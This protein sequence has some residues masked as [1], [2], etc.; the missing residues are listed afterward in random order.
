MELYTIGHS[1]H[2]EKEF[3]KLLHDAGVELLVDVRAFPGSRK[4]PW[5]NTDRMKAWLPENGVGY[6]HIRELGGRRRKSKTVGDEVNAGW[7]NRSFHNYADYTQEGEFKQGLEKLREAA[8]DRR[9]AI[10]CSERHPARCHRMLISNYAALHG[11][12]VFHILDGKE[13]KTVIELHQ[14]GRWG[15]EPVKREDGEVVYPEIN[16]QES[17]AD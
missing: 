2:N 12:D 8:A 13:R 7:N 15:A 14:L 6:I 10:C 16:G 5:F 17:D 1:T 9:V 3:L 11:G 4:F